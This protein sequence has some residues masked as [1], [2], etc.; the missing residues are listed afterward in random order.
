MT[1]NGT[2][3]HLIVV[4]ASAG[5]VDAISRMI[6]TLSEDFPV[7]V[8]VAQHLSPDRESHLQEILSRKSALPVKTV[9]DHEKLRAGTVFVVPADR[10]VNITD[11]TIDL[12]MSS[13][14][15][16]FGE[17]LV[18]IVLSG[19]GSDGAE[20][21]RAVKRAGGT[22]IIQDPETAEFPG[23]PRSLAPNTVD[24][25][26]RLE[27]MGQ[28]L[29]EL[30]AGGA[31]STEKEEQEPLEDFLEELR[32]RHGLDFKSYKE[33]TIRRRLARR[34][35]ATGT[36]S[37]REYRRYLDENSAEYG[38]LV[39]AFLIKVTEFFR[40]PEQFE[41]LREEVL[42][43]VIQRARDG[44]QQLRVWSAG[45]AT[46][47]EAYSLAILI[48][49]AL[50]HEAGNFNVRI[51]ATDLDASA[52]NFARR[53]VYPPSA[54]SGLTNEQILSHFDEEDGHYRVKKSIRSMI[55]FGEH[56]LVQRSPFPQ[57]DLVVSRNVLIY[58]TNVLQRRTLQLFAYSLKD[59]GYLML[60][61]AE[62][63]SPLS[64]Y[65]G[66]VE[67]QHKVYLRQ[68]ERFVMPIANVTEPAPEA[69]SQPLRRK[70]SYHQGA[71]SQREGQ[72][73]G[74][75]EESIINRI[76]VGL[77][78]VD[79]R[80]DILSINTTARRLLSIHGTAVGE[81]LLH[82]I[83]D[84]PYEALRSAID[85]SFREGEP[86]TTGEFAVEDTIN[87]E[88][89]YLDIA[90]HPRREDE[91]PGPASVINIVVSDVTENA[92]KRRELERSLEDTKSEFE[93]YQRDAEEESSRKDQQ[94]RRLIEAN[95]Q[96]EHA[97]QEL[98][99]V[100]EDLQATNEENLLST[101]EAQAATEEVET[102]NEELQATNEELET[103][104][105]ELQATVEELNT[106]NEDLNSRSS[107]LQDFAKNS[108]DEQARL[109]S[110]LDQ[111]PAPLLVVTSRGEVVLTNEEYTKLFNG[112]FILCDHSRAAI[113][114]DEKPQA[115]A[116]RGETFTMQFAIAEDGED[117]RQWY[118]ASARPISA[119]HDLGGVIVLRKVPAPE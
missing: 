45:C 12:L 72:R 106:T 83:R 41:Y 82:L 30:L 69:S 119:K 89:R 3:S 40:D 11:Q 34:L 36:N 77:V 68:G 116:A 95:R 118:E 70:L 18:S 99:R 58:F 17:G 100:N 81:D 91:G 33:P 92:E 63:T 6:S 1:E 42:P 71:S 67:R 110:I 16:V 90:C 57:L 31:V 5:G 49:E 14:A 73:A 101:E 109:L 84:V 44:G 97:N 46:G 53:G 52:V 61:K 115:R 93:Q 117:T 79:R 96:L 76:P 98:A 66:P 47:E 13:A 59:G 25:V 48:S 35:A 19:T 9:T 107:D 32:Q 104:N 2:I 113:S 65:F 80:Y 78:N 74:I 22:V 4:G 88:M 111:V 55:V 23:M 87:G 114:E 85:A 37:L 21:A 54:L 28:I 24:I 10:H 86:N 15:H 64:E 51:F 112:D 50:G 39:N 38:N 75:T 27:D 8:V 29:G 60:G 26:A 62:S 94:N 103:L 56:D 20:G 43:E 7:P 102:L 108:D 105:E